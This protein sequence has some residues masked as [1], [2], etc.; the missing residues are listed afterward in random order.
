MGFAPKGSAAF[1]PWRH[2]SHLAHYCVRLLATTFLYA[3]SAQGVRTFLSDL[4]SEQSHL[5]L[6]QIYIISFKR[7]C[8]IC[9]TSQKTVLFLY[10]TTTKQRKKFRDYGGWAPICPD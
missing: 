10:A 6:V 5:L 1:R 2:C 7:C 8:Q 4:A 9:K 3:S